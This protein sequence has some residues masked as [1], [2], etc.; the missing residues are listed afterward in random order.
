MSDYD[1]D[2]GDPEREANQFSLKQDG[3][4]SAP[5]SKDST[6]S[7]T[8]TSALSPSFSP[9]TQGATLIAVEDQPM[10]FV[11]AL[12]EDLLAVDNAIEDDSA[13]VSSVRI[14]AERIHRWLVK[15]QAARRMELNKLVLAS[16]ARS[17]M[18][19]VERIWISILRV[20]LVG[21]HMLDT[22]LLRSVTRAITDLT[23]VSTTEQ[24]SRFAMRQD[25]G[26]ADFIC[27]TLQSYPQDRVLQ[28]EGLRA[29]TNLACLEP[30]R[31]FM[32][33]KGCYR[34]AALALRNEAL[35]DDR[36]LVE[37]A[38][39]AVAN[40]AHEFA[41]QPAANLDP[42]M[43]CSSRLTEEEFCIAVDA[44]LANMY[45]YALTASVQ[46]RALNALANTMLACPG[47]GWEYEIFVKRV[48]G[49]V[50]NFS[51]TLNIVQ[52]GLMC[53]VNGIRAEA[54]RLVDR[55]VE[56]KHLSSSTLPYP[57]GG[58]YSKSSL[59]ELLLVRLFYESGCLI[60][61]KQASW[62]FDVD[63]TV[64]IWSREAQSL[65]SSEVAQSHCKR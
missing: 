56:S 28:R 15:S 57:E 51:E 22:P 2:G 33:T 27:F 30:V 49:S 48:L 7:R 42:S 63:S 40:L 19:Q 29:A 8:S 3:E 10:P 31:T 65:L 13:P 6:H 26:A 23:T 14:A 37:A 47:C 12:N 38:L 32:A 1:S 5:V 9:T 4:L 50:R 64:E 18:E 44:I 61:V 17:W 34:F 39:G 24:M 16:T 11:D 25:D 55:Q 41:T 58:G 62:T 43:E 20:G 46:A 60:T 45:T 35:N 54:R 52:Y 59:P 36:F 21:R 53:V